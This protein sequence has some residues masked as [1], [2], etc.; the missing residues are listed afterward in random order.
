MESKLPSLYLSFLYRIYFGQGSAV[1]HNCKALV[2]WT[3]SPL[4]V[5]LF[6]SKILRQVQ[7]EHGICHFHSLK[8]IILKLS[9]ALLQFALIVL[10]SLAR[11][12]G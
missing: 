10:P 9:S 6:K 5:F 1:V 12:R 3:F 4:S 8:Y 11:T 7:E 2:D